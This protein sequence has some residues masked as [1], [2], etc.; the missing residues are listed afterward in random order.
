MIIEHD[1]YTAI[2][3]KKG[4]SRP[5]IADQRLVRRQKENRNSLIWH[6]IVLVLR[7]MAV[8]TSLVLCVQI[9]V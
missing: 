7:D 4:A 9:A 1:D 2:D 5:E 8:K 6:R 3:R